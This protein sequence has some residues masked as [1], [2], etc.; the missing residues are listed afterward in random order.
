MTYENRLIQNYSFGTLTNAAAISDTSLVS[1]DFSARLATGLSTTIYVPITLQDPSTGIYE[2][3]WANAHTAASSTATVLRGKESTSARAWPSGTL[4]T[5]APTVRDGLL[6]V[7]TRSALPT[8]PHAGIRAE[9]QD[10]QVVV[11]WS[12]SSGWTSPLRQ[13]AGRIAGTS[14]IL[15]TT[16]N[17]TTETNIPKL[18]ITGVKTRTGN[19]YVL[20]TSFTIEATAAN[21]S[22]TIRVRKDTALSGT[23]LAT[24]SWITDIAGFTHSNGF[25]LPWKAV[26]D[27]SNTNFYVSIQREAGVGTAD[28]D[29]GRCSFDVTDCGSD[30]SVW[31]IVP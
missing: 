8:D 7:T 18:A 20:R 12:V 31:A 13:L 15:Q 16:P 14:G 5:V 4:W 10:E 6:P 27:N 25:S 26:A 28:L 24:W 19:F 22:Y 29:G 2:I 11:E 21:D 30:S 9:I 17:N 3:V 23:V 1:N